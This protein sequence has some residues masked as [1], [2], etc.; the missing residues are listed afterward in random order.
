MSDILIIAPTGSYVRDPAQKQ[1]N[2][3]I[4]DQTDAIN[5]EKKYDPQLPKGTSH[6]PQ[7]MELKRYH[8]M[9]PIRES[10]PRQDQKARF[11]W[12]AKDEAKDENRVSFPETNDPEKNN[13]YI[14]GF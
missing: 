8:D 12:F 14:R 10:V 3:V 9:R 1:I 13:K 7:D 5:I 2:D 6:A 11:L 4:K